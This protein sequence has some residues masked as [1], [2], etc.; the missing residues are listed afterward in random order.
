MARPRPALARRLPDVITQTTL[1]YLY[2]AA[3]GPGEALAGGVKSSANVAA[4]AGD[5]PAAARVVRAVI[6]PDVV[7]DI[8]RRFPGAVVVSVHAEEEAGRNKLPTVYAAALGDIGGLAVDD[9]VVQVNRVHH[10]GATARQRL[11]RRPSFVGPVKLGSDYVLCD[12][13][14]TSGSSL[15]ALRHFV[16]ARRPGGA[17]DDPRL[18]PGEVRNES[19]PARQ[20]AGNGRGGHGEIRPGPAGGYTL[21]VWHCPLRPSPHRVR[22]PCPPRIRLN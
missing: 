2:G 12:D 15:A 8:G 14:V 7:A 4:K 5:V 16:E 9:A 10:T 1:E 3:P 20:P 11:A 13:V 21:P 6:R 17:G 22:R 19:D 18:R